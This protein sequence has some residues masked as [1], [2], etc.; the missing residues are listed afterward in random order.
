MKAY[1]ESKKIYVRNDDKMAYEV[2]SIEIYDGCDYMKLNLVL[3]A[4]WDYVN[5]DDNDI[6]GYVGA[7]RFVEDVQTE[8]ENCYFM[9][10]SITECLEDNGWII[11]NGNPL[12]YT[13][14]YL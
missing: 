6:Q 9:K 4:G 2:N 8:T 3:V 7:D 10:E 12:G 5:P 14:Q 13:E 11:L 1:L